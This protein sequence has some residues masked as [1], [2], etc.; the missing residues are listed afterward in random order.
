MQL[1]SIDSEPD[2]LVKVTLE[3]CRHLE[4][5]KNERSLESASLHYVLSQSEIPT[6]TNSLYY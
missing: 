1:K 2:E 6:Y 5:E 4:E 3:N